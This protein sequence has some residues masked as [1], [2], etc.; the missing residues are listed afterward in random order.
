MSHSAITLTA[1]RHEHL[2]GAVR[3]SQ[4]AKWPH[5]LEDWRMALDLSA[6]IVAVD[7]NAA[8]VLGTVL[9]TPYKREVATVS[10]VMVDEIARGHGLGRKI[11]EAAIA[12]AGSRALRLIAT[13]EGL[14]LYQKLGFRE[15][16]G[17]VHHQGQARR[18][19]PPANVRP[20]QTRDIPKIMHLDTAAYGANREPLIRYIANVGR[21][22][23]LDHGN[24]VAGFAAL[25][26]FGRGEVIGPVV[27]GN[28]DD[29][30][31]LLAHFIAGQEA[32]F[33]RVDTA[34]ASLLGPWL[35]EAGLV[36]VDDGIVME[37]PIIPRTSGATPLTTFALTSQAFG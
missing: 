4:Q 17:I 29:A 8:T 2:A 19:R 26:A 37:R 1:F 32:Q 9:M 18:V 15:M 12:L 16:G 34:E 7:A 27:A 3:L 10:M 22:A 21:L 14:P 35:T 28:A 33:V 36:R 31:A 13:R 20:A 5:R 30:K 25:R 23:V 11:M 24:E 6:G